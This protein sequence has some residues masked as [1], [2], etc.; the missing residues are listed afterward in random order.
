MFKIILIRVAK[1]CPIVGI[2]LCSKMLYQLISLTINFKF[3]PTV[4]AFNSPFGF[5]FLADDHMTHFI[6]DGF[7]R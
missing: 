3:F 4:F 6:P 7:I 1:S 2:M 5:K